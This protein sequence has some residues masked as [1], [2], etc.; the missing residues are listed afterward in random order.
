MA[1]HMF[2][3]SMS[4][5]H[6]FDPGTAES[7]ADVLYEMGKDLLVKQQYTMA[8]KWLDRAYQILIEQEL[9]RLS[10]DA[11]ELRISIVESLIK[12][13][14]GIQDQESADKARSL[15][16]FL[17]NEVGDKLIV[18]LLRLDLL[19]ATTNESFDS[20]SYSDI[21]RRM[22]RTVVLT[23]PNFKLIMYHIRK[24]NDRS[25]GLACKALDELLRLRILQAERDEWIEKVIITR[26]WMTTN[27][28]DTPDALALL[29][30]V[31]SAIFESLGQPISSAVTLAAHT[32]RS[33][34][35]ESFDR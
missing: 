6:F 5:K 11:S 22:T 4:S 19:S 20:N 23:E 34:D 27:Q 2:K 16:D 9:D 12:A 18:L 13:L 35:L 29:E 14:L 31:L 15:V 24:L 8:V 7:L 3:K 1:E 10:M 21:L 30:E 26:L 28:R 17:E 33:L 25:P 32:V